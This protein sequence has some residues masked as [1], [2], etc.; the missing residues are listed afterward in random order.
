[1][2]FCPFCSAE[3]A[4]TASHCATCARRLP[5]LPPRRQKTQ[6]VPTA[7][8][9][10]LPSAPMA[11]PST[12]PAPITPPA[13]ST[14]PAPST[15]PAPSEPPVIVPPT[16]APALPVPAVDA[17]ALRAARVPP[18][19]ALRRVAPEPEPRAGADGRR[20]TDQPGHVERPN[21]DLDVGAAAPSPPDAPA[22]DTAIATFVHATPIDDPAPTG[23][24][25]LIL[26]S[27]DARAGA[28]RPPEPAQP[29]RPKTPTQPPP[30][31]TG[32]AKTPTQPPPTPQPLPPRLPPT[33]SSPSVRMARDHTVVDPPPTR[34][35]RPDALIDRP[36]TP[37]LV[38][39]IPEVPEPGL[40][41]AA[42][43]AYT[44]VRARWQRRSAIKVLGDEIKGET[45]ALDQVLGE[46]GKAARTG[47]VEGR[48]FASENAGISAAE[49][50]RDQ[51]DRENADLASRRDDENAKFAEVE[52]DRLAKQ[53]DA[54]KLVADA[55]RELGNF[56]GQRRSLRDKRK[57]IERRQR[58]FLKAAEDRDAEAGNAPMGD[59]RSLL[60]RQA[61]D[62]RREAAALEPE[63]QD[64]DRRIAALERPI[65]DAQGKV[66]A[67]RGELDAARRS[68][69]DARE[70]HTHRKAEIEAEQKRKA[71]EH[72]Q[73]DAEIQR[74]LVTL[75]TLVNLNRVERAEF[76][77]L[78]ARIDRLR[79]AIAAR[80]TE[81]EKL[82][83]ER[84]A[85]DKGSLVRGLVVIG[86]GAVGIVTLIVIVLAMF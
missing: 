14:A 5:P 38:L 19:T 20:R 39:P 63:R 25:S 22:D 72:T 49:A 46:L 13:P 17:R 24:L 30:M 81:I 44:F 15:V 23:D 3:N 59:T 53:T 76:A 31:P 60:R 33:P 86:G 52:R 11:T 79:T 58:A 77:D 78:Y 28:P 75:G 57:E 1:V 82:T 64:L 7:G 10:Q 27:L 62:H 8:V 66:D 55:Q 35:A 41:H 69:S 48:A 50:R 32:R 36:F 73:A 51:L 26:R 71:R 12:A 9:S 74:R 54:E 21:M 56:E 67:A 80:T 18:P 16:A 29:G 34:I 83:A 84:E 65:A 40:L 2:R 85:Y 61:E 6:A 68:L 70:G 43:Y 47:H 37:P 4:D 45:S 42:R